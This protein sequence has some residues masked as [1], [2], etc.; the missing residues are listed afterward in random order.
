MP[1]PQ[2]IKVGVW[3]GGDFIGAILFGRGANR[4]ALAFAGFAQLE[5]AELVRVA[6]TRHAHPVTRMVSIALKMLR[7]HSPGTRVVFSY[8]DPK[9]GHLGRIY[10]A[11]NWIYVG[12]GS[13]TREFFYQGRWV[14]N[15]VM[16]GPMFNRPCQYSTRGCAVR[17]VPGKHKYLFPLDRSVRPRLEELR[18]PYPQ[19]IEV[20]A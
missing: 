20:A 19:Q 9:Q 8:A 4:S 11:G 15:R 13:P 12:R 1:M 3:E 7:G 2:L 10:Q 16:T 6:L 17:T 5:S 18:Q 14:H